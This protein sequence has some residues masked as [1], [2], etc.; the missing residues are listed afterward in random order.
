MSADPMAYAKQ[1]KGLMAQSDGKDK[2]L[3][4]V[5][6]AAMFASG[7]EAGTALSVQKSFGAARKPFRL[8]KPFEFV[9]PILQNPPRGK[10]LA[11]ALEYTKALGMA[12]YM[13]CDHFVW[14]GQAGVLTDKKLAADMQK[15]SFWGW[16]VASVAGLVEQ[17]NALNAALDEMSAA[18]DEV[19]KRAAAVRV[20]KIMFG[21]VTNS[22]QGLLALS[23]LEKIP[24]MDKRK[25][26]ALGIFLS[27]LNCYNLAP[28]LK[29][30]TA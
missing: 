18:A 17:T 20:Q 30:K 23:L 7:G 24:A 29:A 5:Q 9:M 27:L 6:Y 22:A 4:L 19:E 26:G 1:L 21:I 25:T 11:V 2:V 14:A 16:F 15:V 28:P 13:G 10:A 3:A 8:Y 12:V